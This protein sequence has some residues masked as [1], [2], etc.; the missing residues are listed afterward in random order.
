M[1]A[2]LSLLLGLAAVCLGGPGTALAGSAND[3]PGV[4]V[5]LVHGIW[6]N[7][8][9]FDPMV[10]VLE[11]EGRAC[12]APDLLPNDG[13]LGI[14]P[15][16]RQLAGKIDARFGP[17]A[18]VVLVGFSMGGLVARDYVENVAANPCRVRGVF[19]VA[20]AGEGTLWANLSP[21]AGQRDMAIGSPFLRAL[22]A[23]DAAWKTI[24][25]HAYWTPFD[26][27]VVPAVHSRWP[28]RAATCVFC[29]VHPWMPRNRQVIADIAARL[30]T[31]PAPPQNSG[32]DW[33][34]TEEPRRTGPPKP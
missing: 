22:N 4:N 11:R 24:P 21:R 23:E 33:L 8:R 29:P 12:F 34:T 5:V 17:S 3:P 7:G 32:T 6:D 13:H 18:P 2:K 28:E 19:L 9:I 10:R 1:P 20:S 15:L 16:T 27:M 14:R 30:R 31:L 25:L 26:L